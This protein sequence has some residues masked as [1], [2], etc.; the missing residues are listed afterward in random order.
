MPDP[1]YQKIHHP[2]KVEVF[3]NSD[4]TLGVCLFKAV[5]LGHGEVKL[6]GHI[7]REDSKIFKRSNAPHIKE[8]YGRGPWGVAAYHE[9]DDE[10]GMIQ[11]ELIVKHF[12]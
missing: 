5:Q 8:M 12:A 11:I 10:E 6:F 9:Y 1:M 3:I 4:E 2:R 7:E